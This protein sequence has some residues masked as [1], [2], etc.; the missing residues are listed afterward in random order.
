MYIYIKPKMTR[1]ISDVFRGYRKRHWHEMC[2]KIP[3]EQRNITSK[4][5]FPIN[6]KISFY[7]QLEISQKLFS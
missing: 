1:Q 4:T 7:H 5:V 6:K 2:K 3:K